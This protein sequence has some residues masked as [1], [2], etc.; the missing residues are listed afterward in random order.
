MAEAI[1]TGLGEMRHETAWAWGLGYFI[2]VMLRMGT[3]GVNA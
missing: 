1:Q 2:L 3:G